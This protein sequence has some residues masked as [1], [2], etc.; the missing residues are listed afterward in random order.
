MHSGINTGLVVTAEVDPKKGSQGVTGDSVNL[1]ARL[2][3]LAG[4]DEILVGGEMARRLL[5]RF[6]FQDLGN[7]RIKGKAESVSVYKVLPL[8]RMGQT[9]DRQVASVMVG[10]DRELDRLTLQVMKVVNGE[11]SVVNVI[12]EAGI[13]KSRLIAE[14]QSKETPLRKSR[15][16]R[17]GPFP[18][19]GT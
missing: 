12:G 10:R 19:A 2:S 13:G 1:A 11:G 16:W 5:G 15:S 18:S 4:P 3:S 17:A 7:K 14:F 6:L 9:P 8:K